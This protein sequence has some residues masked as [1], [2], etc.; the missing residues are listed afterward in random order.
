[1]FLGWCQLLQVSLAYCAGLSG[2]KDFNVI[3]VIKTASFDIHHIT[4]TLV[5]HLKRLSLAMHFRPAN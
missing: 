2:L 5:V 3:I 4:I 1:M